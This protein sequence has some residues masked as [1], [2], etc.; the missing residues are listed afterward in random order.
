MHFVIA[1][2]Q[3][4]QPVA[5]DRVGFDLPH[6]A[7]RD[8]DNLDIDARECRAGRIG[9]DALQARADSLG[10]HRARKQV[11]RNAGSENAA[12]GASTH[13]APLFRRWPC[14]PADSLTP[15]A[16]FFNLQ[17]WM[18]GEALDEGFTPM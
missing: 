2:R 1:G 7:G 4:R 15:R 14:R 13:D 6:R 10:L 3:H 9:D 18:P 17:D 11:D 8:A 5:A 12:N 16:P